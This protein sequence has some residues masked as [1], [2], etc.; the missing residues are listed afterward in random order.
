[1][2]VALVCPY[3]LERPGGGQQHVLELAFRLERRG[4]DARV[5]APGLP[6]GLAGTDLGGS[7]LVRGNRSSTPISLD[8]KV[9]RMTRR[10][11]AAA[12]VVH[13]HEPFMPLVSLAALNSGQPTVATF[14]ADPPSWVGTAYRLGRGWG[15]RLLGG[16]VLTA[17]SPVAASSVPSSWG[18]IEVIPIG[19]DVASYGGGIE[20]L[21]HRVCF[22]GRDDPRKGLDVLLS[23]WSDIKDRCPA[24]ELVVLGAVRPDA[25]PGV[26]FLG[27]VSEAEKRRVL[28]VSAVFVAP[29]TG[30]ESFG[31]VVAEAMASGCAVVATDLPAFRWVTGKAALLVPPGDSRA[32]AA[33]V[34]QL[35][36]T[37]GLTAKIGASSASQAARFDWEVVTDAYLASYRLAASGLPG[38]AK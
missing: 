28:A 23:A 15:R 18:N 21:E 26:R 13:V 34:I 14:H 17:V 29:N 35:L 19:L 4:V 11:I 3:N 37:P 24:A 7:V 12:D 30:A 16:A 33:A 9:W 32:L 2:H 5:V 31:T 6:D 36:Q 10:A 8:P 38:A 27:R 20:R 22:L 25:P 1:M